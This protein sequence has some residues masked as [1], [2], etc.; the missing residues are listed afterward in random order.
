VPKSRPFSDAAV[1]GRPVGR[2]PTAGVNEP[3][4]PAKALIAVRRWQVKADVLGRQQQ[5]SKS[6]Q[7]AGELSSIRGQ[8]LRERKRFDAQAQ[9]PSARPDLSSDK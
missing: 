5:G 1:P 9:K 4:Q 2:P 3:S 6:N 7:A 8:E